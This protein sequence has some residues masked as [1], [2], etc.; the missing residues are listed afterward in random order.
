[1][2]LK[3][4]NDFCYNAFLMR[5]LGVKQLKKNQLVV[6]ADLRCIKYG[7]EIIVNYS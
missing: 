4:L 3:T 1:M 6:D 5:K 7:C 2:F